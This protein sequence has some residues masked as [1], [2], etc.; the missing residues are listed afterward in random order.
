MTFIRRHIATIVIYAGVLV[1]S[2]AR[3]GNTPHP[4]FTGWDKVVHLCMYAALAAIMTGEYVWHHRWDAVP[5]RRYIPIIVTASAYGLAIEG[6]QWLLPYRSAEWLDA[7]A[8]ATGAI[9]GVVAVAWGYGAM[10]KRKR[11][12]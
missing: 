10:V 12:G 2:A 3:F 1:L 7:A 4:T 11:R 9:L 5:A 8:N 6:V